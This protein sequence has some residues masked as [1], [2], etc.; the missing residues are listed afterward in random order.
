MMKRK[1]LVLV[2]T[3]I[4]SLGVSVLAFAGEAITGKLMKIEEKKLTVQTKDKKEVT[5]EVN[6]IEGTLK[7]GDNIIIK[8]GVA[9]R[10]KII[11]GC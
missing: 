4:F 11:E 5:A 6:T 7:T 9:K 1:I 2:I 10:K 8:D 3:L